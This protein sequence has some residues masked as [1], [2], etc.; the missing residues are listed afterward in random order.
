[1]T[2]NFDRDSDSFMAD[3]E[4]E[5]LRSQLAPLSRAY[6]RE[7]LENME[8]SKAYRAG[9]HKM[10]LS[11]VREDVLASHRRASWHARLAGRWQRWQDCWGELVTSSLWFR[12]GTQGVMALG[13]GLLLSMAW[14]SA[15]NKE[16][17]A[18][19]THQEWDSELVP[20]LSWRPRLTEDEELP[21]SPLG[22]LPRIPGELLS[23]PRRQR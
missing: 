7:V 16:E 12:L 8:P 3:E 23:H 9:M 2:E 17:A 22:D 14:V 5:A 10:M 13:L 21:P 18:A 19:R 4:L 11:L 6:H 20:Q 15:M 1:M